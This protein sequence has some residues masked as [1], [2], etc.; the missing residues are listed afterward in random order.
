MDTFTPH[1]TFV[2]IEVTEMTIALDTLFQ[3][4]PHGPHA[5][6]GPHGGT[7]MGTWGGGMGTE[8]GL[9][10][11]LVALVLGVGVV[12]VAA[13]ILLRRA[14]GVRENGAIRRP[15]VVRRRHPREQSF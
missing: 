6:M 5:P 3:W 15:S 2:R 14:D 12:V 9:L 11:L 7:A 1:V 13:A 8:W 4:V 10:W